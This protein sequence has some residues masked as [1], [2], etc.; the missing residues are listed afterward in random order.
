MKER[1]DRMQPFPVWPNSR[2]TAAATMKKGN[3]VTS[4]I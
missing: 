3:S 1:L 4:D 2:A